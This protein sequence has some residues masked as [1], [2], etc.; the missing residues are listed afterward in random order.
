MA[1]SAKQFLV[2]DDKGNGH[3][4]VRQT[5]DGPLDHGLMGGA[6]AALFARRLSL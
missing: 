1:D 2:I 6:H 5:P 4:K 3:L